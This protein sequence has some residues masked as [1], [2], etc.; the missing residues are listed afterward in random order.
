MNP[1]NGLH[2]AQA[3]NPAGGIHLNLGR[4]GGNGG[5]CDSDFDKY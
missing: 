5:A 4:S 2:Q 3:K 1:K